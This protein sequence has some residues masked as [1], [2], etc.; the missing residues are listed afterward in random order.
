VDDL[1]SVAKQVW[2]R[3]ERE[4]DPQ[5]YGELARFLDIGERRI[6]MA[7][8]ELRKS[9]RPVWSDPSQA[10]YRIAK[11]PE[12]IHELAARFDGTA[13][14]HHH[15][16]RQLRVLGPGFLPPERPTQKSL[17]GGSHE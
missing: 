9:G 16:A 11:S 1:S 10:G 2:R 14:T 6:R 8:E 17:F 3:L 7:I 5:T 15:T 4:R 13:L 12:E